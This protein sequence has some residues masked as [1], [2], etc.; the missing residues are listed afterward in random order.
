MSVTSWQYWIFNHAHSVALGMA[1]LVGPDRNISM[2]VGL[3]FHDMLY[4]HSW[5]LESYPSDFSP[6]FSSSAIQVFTYPVKYLID[7]LAQTL[8][9]TFTVI[10]L[11]NHDFGDYLTFPL[12]PPAAWHSW[13]WVNCL[14]NYWMDCHC[15][16]LNL[17]YCAIIRSKCEFVQYFCLWSKTHKKNGI[18]INV[19]Q[20]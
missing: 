11:M 6:D 8:V 10:R 2:T 14:K 17:S 18:P 9:Q 16:P 4:K 13:L 20:V 19:Q 1:T 7:G 12:G 3:G 5:F 15:H